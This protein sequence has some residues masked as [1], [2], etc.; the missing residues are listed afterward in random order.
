[1][2]QA[3]VA[4]ERGTDIVV[5][6]SSSHGILR[7]RAREPFPLSLCCVLPIVVKTYVHEIHAYNGL[8]GEMSE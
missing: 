4:R 2:K 3:V 6:E 5:T 8:P 1:M 7:C